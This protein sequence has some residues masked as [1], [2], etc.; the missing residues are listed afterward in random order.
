MLLPGWDENKWTRLHCS[1]HVTL[2]VSGIMGHGHNSSVTKPRQDLT[3]QTIRQ[4][5]PWLPQ[6]STIMVLEGYF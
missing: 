6:N 4:A 5:G 1:F 2:L 3:D